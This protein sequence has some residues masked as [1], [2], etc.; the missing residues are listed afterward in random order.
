MDM[1][2]VKVKI[3]CA[4]KTIKTFFYLHLLNSCIFF[5]DTST[6]FSGHFFKLDIFSGW[7]PLF[8]LFFMRHFIEIASTFYLKLYLHMYVK[9]QHITKDMSTS[10]QFVLKSAPKRKNCA[11]MQEAVVNKIEIIWNYSSAEKEH[12]LK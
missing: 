12:I 10:G 2:I 11:S 8:C 1:F 9:L 7:F 5:F 3:R 4:F 6:F